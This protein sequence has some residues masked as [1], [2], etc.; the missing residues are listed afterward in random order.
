MGR[1]GREDAFRGRS[2][3]WLCDVFVRCRHG[4]RR[5]LRKATLRSIAKGSSP[6]LKEFLESREPET[7]I[8]FEHFNQKFFAS[9]EIQ[10]QRALCHSAFLGHG[11]HR[12]RRV[13]RLHD[14]FL[15]RLQKYLV[16]LL[17]VCL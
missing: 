1:S 5:Y 11:L 3:L 17:A 15:R 2:C 13:S 12:H 9:L 8:I 6:T 4:G 10:I 7:K 14:D 16:T